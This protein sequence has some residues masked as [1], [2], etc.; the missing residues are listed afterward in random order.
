MLQ[1]ISNRTSTLNLGFINPPIY[2]KK[3]KFMS[4]GFFVAVF[5]D[6]TIYSS[7]KL[8]IWA[9]INKRFKENELKYQSAFE[10][11]SKLYI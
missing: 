7:W 11:H 1:I 2:C 8:I 6:P 10:N 9:Y 3:L 4:T 5:P